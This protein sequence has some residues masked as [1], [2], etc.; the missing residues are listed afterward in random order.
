L[1]D[2]LARGLDGFREL[3]DALD[4]RRIDLQNLEHLITA[5]S[6]NLNRSS[7]VHAL[8]K[9][10]GV[11]AGPFLARVLKND[12]DSTVRFHAARALSDL[13]AGC[14][15]TIPALVQALND[16]QVDSATELARLGKPGVL[17][18]MPAFVAN[19]LHG[20]P[21]TLG[22]L[23]TSTGVGALAGG[24]YLA[25]RTTVVGLGRVVMYSTLAFGAALIAFA[26]AKTLWM[27]LL[28]LPIVGAGFMV[29]MAATNT[30][31]QTL[32]DDHPRGRVMAFYTMAFFGTSPIGSLLA[33]VAADRIGARWTIGIA[34]ACS[35]A[36][37][38]WF[39]ARLPALRALVRPIYIERGILPVPAVDSG[40]KTL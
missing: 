1:S 24:F 32:V 34:G 22:L 19:V 8:P 39:A 36:A 38:L 35:L 23:M 13:G 37:G 4:Q 18:L 7:A 31:L 20:G 27:S 40:V 12:K 21:S 10:E 26:F 9:I 15:E 2:A 5:D 28:I 30:V 6:D 25:N 29:Q 14:P 11:S 3:A 17:A 16:D 33:G